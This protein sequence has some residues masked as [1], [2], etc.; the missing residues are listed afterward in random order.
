[1]FDKPVVN[2]G[3]DP[4]KVTVRVPYARY[5]EYDHYRPLVENG[6]VQLARS[7]SEMRALLRDGLNNPLK[8]QAQWRAFLGKMFGK[9]LDGRAGERVAATLV[10]LAEKMPTRDS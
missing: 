8:H 6:V 10:D 2:V 5:Y 1:M 4:P 3:Y 7:R 9:T